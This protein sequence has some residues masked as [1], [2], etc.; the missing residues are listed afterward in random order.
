MSTAGEVGCPLV[1]S[2]NNRFCLRGRCCSVVMADGRAVQ[3]AGGIGGASLAQEVGLDWC[4][5]SSEP[6][7]CGAS[8]EFGGDLRRDGTWVRQGLGDER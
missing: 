4:G 6:A 5:E 7:W 1:G 2:H 8:A 3:G